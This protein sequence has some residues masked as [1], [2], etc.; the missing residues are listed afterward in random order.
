[1]S[2]E[3]ALALAQAQQET[4]AP[5]KGDRLDMAPGVAKP[6]PAP[7]EYNDL[8]SL[9]IGAGDVASFG[10]N[11]EA[12]AGI[13]SLFGEPYA[14]ALKTTRGGLAEAAAEHPIASTVG[15]VAGVVPSMILPAS[16]AFRAASLG[17]KV[18]RSAIAGG[19]SGAAYGFGSGEGTPEDRLNSAASGAEWGAGMGAVAPAVGAGV[20]KVANAILN[21]GGQPVTMTLDA[22]R[23]AKDAAYQAVDNLGFRYK[24]A[25]LDTLMTGIKNDVAAAHINP[26]R[27][28]QASSMIDTL[29]TELKKPL[30]LTELDQLR[31]VVRRDVSSSNDPAERMFGRKITDKIDEFVNASGSG[32]QEINTA[33]DLNTRV[34]K[35]EAVSDAVAAAERR[36]AKTG[37]GGNV[38]NAT[39]QNI[40]RVASKSYYSPAETAAADRVVMPG[41]VHDAL[42]NVG[43]LSPT[44]G[45]LTAMLETFGSMADHRVMIPAAVGFVAKSLADHLT[46]R[47][48]KQLERVIAGGGKPLAQAPS[49]VQKVA[50]ALA[51]KGLR[52]GSRGTLPSLLPRQP[53]FS[54][55]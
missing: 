5:G 17:G 16:N 30:S 41:R 20:G 12:A 22:L 25:A 3:E 47:N 19:T 45:G 37:T 42:R 13:R 32:S 48:V 9:L 28:P 55:Q 10:F 27:H 6:A 53:A 7:N 31:Q 24:P 39:R 23:A 8:E 43:R 54:G 40:D 35:M 26:L 50:E 44:T 2:P 4:P 36:A 18:L 29:E 21:R 34:S 11:D 52:V 14:D 38:D 46:T 33:R 15:N 1:M 49:A 51:T